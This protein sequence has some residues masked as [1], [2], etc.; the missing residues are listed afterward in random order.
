M[1]NFKVCEL[2]SGKVL[3]EYPFRIEGDL[4]RLLQAYGEGT[5]ALP[6]FD[7]EGDLV[8]DTWEQ[9][10]L[11]W[12]TL[13]VVTDDLDRILW[14]GIPQKRGRQA[15]SY[16]RFPC[17]TIEAYL[18]DR[19]VP[20]LV[21]KRADQTSGIFRALVEVAGREI[22]LEYDCPPSGVLRDREYL[23]SENARVY[24][25]VN[26]LAAVIDGFNWTIE[27]SW[28]DEDHTFVRKTVRTGYPYLGNRDD[29]PAH[30]FELGQNITDFDY[31][32]DWTTGNSA[33]HVQGVGDT[34]DSTEPPTRLLGTPVV[35]TLRESQ[36]WPRR[37]YRETFSGVKDKPTIDRHTRAVAAQMFGGQNVLELTARNPGEGEEFTRLGDFTLGDTAHAV[38]DHPA[39]TL[40]AVLPVVGWSLTPN[41]GIYKPVLAQIGAQ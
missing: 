23:A 40:D 29:N 8:S 19:Y 7:A 6:L 5:L 11:P 25:R 17:R 33:T 36:G 13:I 16:V 14:H 1:L 15:S 12:R 35:D 21:F 31:D 34:D 22:G 4:T 10:I 26:D 37:E 32:D 28:G 30:Y 9:A 38:I 24:D 3:D 18:I 41:T 2:V 39:L 27:L 20:D